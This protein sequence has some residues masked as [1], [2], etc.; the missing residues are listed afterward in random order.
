[1]SFSFI[2]VGT[3]AA[4]RVTAH[5]LSMCR[6]SSILAEYYGKELRDRS[7]CSDANHLI[8]NIMHCFGN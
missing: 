6:N 3:I 8:S 2:F 1:M 5:L 4:V 7:I